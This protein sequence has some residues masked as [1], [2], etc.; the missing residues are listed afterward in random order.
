MCLNYVVKHKFKTKVVKGWKI[1]EEIDGGLYSYYKHFGI[2]K[3]TNKL[4]GKDFL[5]EDTY[6]TGFHIYIDDPMLRNTVPVTFKAVD[7]RCVGDDFFGLTAVV[8]AYK[9]KR[10]DYDNAVLELSNSHL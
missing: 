5:I 3:G 8:K 7:V 2:V 6:P 1:V 4:Q 9:I 10:K